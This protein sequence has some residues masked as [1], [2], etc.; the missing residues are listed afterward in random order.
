MRRKSSRKL[1]LKRITFLIF[2]ILITLLF[3]YLFLTTFIV[4]K[5]EIITDGGSC[6]EK[7]QIEQNINLLGKN[8]FFLDINKVKQNLQNKFVCIK[9]VNSIKNYPT[10]MKLNIQSRQPK[11]SLTSVGINATSSADLINLTQNSA[12]FSAKLIENKE[13]FY[14]DD[15]G[16]IYSKL[17]DQGSILNIK[18]VN[19][20]LNIG[21]RLDKRIVE[22]ILKI[23][24]KTGDQGI[25]IDKIFLHDNNLFIENSNSVL[26][27]NTM[28]KIDTQIASLQLIV[29]KAKIENENIE[30]ID[31][32]FDKPVVKYAKR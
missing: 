15:E 7:R 9:D 16:V 26:I 24:Q 31:L 20:D 17:V 22:N 2:I 3:S 25:V 1:S 10:G 23:F 8:L 19:K 32:R 29:Q 13:N 18:V 12:T 30:F 27:F 14:I 21:Q 4:K 28:N 11:I 6:V 5:I